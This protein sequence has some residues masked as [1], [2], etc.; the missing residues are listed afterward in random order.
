[1][2]IMVWVDVFVRTL[3]FPVLWLL[4][5]PRLFTPEYRF[6]QALQKQYGQYNLVLYGPIPP[7]TQDK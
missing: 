5:L 4:L 1:M 2:R 6:Q 3:F 7:D